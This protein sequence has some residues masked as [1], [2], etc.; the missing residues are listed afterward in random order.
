MD[1]VSIRASRAGGDL[2]G[3][4]LRRAV[5]LFQSAPPAREATLSIYTI[6]KQRGILALARNCSRRPAIVTAGSSFL[7][8][9]SMR[10]W[11]CDNREHS[12]EIVSAWG[13]RHLASKYHQLIW[14]VRRLRSD[15]L[16]APAPVGAEPIEAQAIGFLIYL[17]EQPGAKCCPLG[18]IDLALEDRIL[19]PLSKVPAEPSDAPEPAA[20][21]RIASCYIIGDQHQ[22][23]RFYLQTNGG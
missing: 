1:H 17:R 5:V 15:M 7:R 23:G 8:N 20:T 3:H 2:R 21:G 18:S 12:G 6:V 14:I 22:H 4:L 16:Y 13:S 11:P 10:S 9:S 19:D